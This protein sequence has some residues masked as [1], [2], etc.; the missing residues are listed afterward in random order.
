MVVH[1]ADN[2]HDFSLVGLWA[3]LINNR[4]LCTQL[5]GHGPRPNN[6]SDIGRNNQQVFWL[7]PPQFTVQYRCRINIVYRHIKESLYLISMQIHGNYPVG[8]CYADHIGDQFSGDCDPGSPRTSVLTRI[9]VIRH[10]G[11]HPFR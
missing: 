1:R 3:T 6:T 4:Q 10:Y 5:L 7:L 9:T 11:R 8:S 2:V